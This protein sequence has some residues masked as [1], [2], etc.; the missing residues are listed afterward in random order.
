MHCD[1]FPFHFGKIGSIERTEV[2]PC[3][4]RLVSDSLIKPGGTIGILPDE[5]GVQHHKI[6]VG[7]K[8]SVAVL[9]ALG[10]VASVAIGR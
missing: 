10:I 7:T 4:L 6:G 9:D 2:A 1:Q 5:V 8:K 3:E